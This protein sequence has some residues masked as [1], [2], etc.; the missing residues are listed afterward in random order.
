MSLFFPNMTMKRY[1]L[2]TSQ[3]RGVYGETVKE[4][5]Y[6]CD[7]RVDFQHEN[8]LEYAQRYGVERDNLYKIYTDLSVT[9]LDD[10]VLV[11][12]EG[13]EYQIIGEI[14]DYNHFHN[15]RRVHLQRSR[16]GLL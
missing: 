8:N 4:Y 13:K 6:T 2:T 16:G 7:L 3:R 10:D 5:Q 15:Y 14:Q 9:L 12:P 1:T 11:D